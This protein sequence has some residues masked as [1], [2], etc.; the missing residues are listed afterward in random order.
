MAVV[1]D[2]QNANRVCNKTPF[3]NCEERVTSHP[4][5]SLIPGRKRMHIASDCASFE[6][7][8]RHYIHLTDVVV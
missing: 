6:A 5:A 3:W 8:M 1:P 7:G 2:L 4:Y